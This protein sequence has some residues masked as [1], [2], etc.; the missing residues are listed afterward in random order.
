MSAITI[1]S[2]EHVELTSLKHS[3]RCDHGGKALLVCCPA[4]PSVLFEGSTGK[5][6]VHRTH[7][8]TWNDLRTP[9]MSQ[10]KEGTMNL[11]DWLAPDFAI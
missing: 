5:S 3:G 4:K 10:C 7:V 11:L 8:P 2:T 9:D 1:H 6:D